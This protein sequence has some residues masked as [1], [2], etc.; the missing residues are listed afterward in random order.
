M[1][2]NVKK[3]WYHIYIYE[4]Q[5]LNKYLGYIDVLSFLDFKD[6]DSQSFLKT[7]FQIDFAIQDTILLTCLD[8]LL[9]I[10]YSKIRD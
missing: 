9:V 2:K 5:D 1:T 8:A 10:G 4:H 7:G 3:N 6:L